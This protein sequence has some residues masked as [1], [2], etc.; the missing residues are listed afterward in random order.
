[1]TLEGP[2]LLDRT[3]DHLDVALGTSPAPTFPAAFTGSNWEVLDA[4]ATPTFANRSY[5]DL[6]GYNIDM[7]T[8]FIQQVTI[9]EAHSVFGTAPCFVM[10]MVSTEFI[11]D[12]TL[13]N[14]FTYTTGD[15]DPPGFPRSVFN[16]E[17][18]IYGRMR[19]Y[20][21]ST[22]W[23]D[24]GLQGV[25]TWGTGAATSAQKLYCTRVV[26]VLAPGSSGQTVHLPACNYVVAAIIAKEKELTYLMR[27]FRS[28]ELA[29]GT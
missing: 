2:R 5:F 1:M 18:I 6:S 16:M 12:T 24:L 26:Y 22:Q 7:L 25:T 13:L 23:S 21:T 11:D 27:Q 29:P 10:D 3:L 19:M 8:T 28:Y 4:V 17:Q 14:A 15:G 9:Q 20:Q